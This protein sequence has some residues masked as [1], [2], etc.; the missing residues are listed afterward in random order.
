MEHVQ[1]LLAAFTLIQVNHTH[2]ASVTTHPSPSLNRFSLD[3]GH[4]L[5]YS[6]ITAHIV[7]VIFKIVL[8]Y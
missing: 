7:I 4:V 1:V 5:L 3:L 8:T 2:R 6:I